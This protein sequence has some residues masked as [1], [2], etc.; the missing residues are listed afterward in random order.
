MKTSQFVSQILDI[1]EILL[2]SG[3]E[4]NRVEDTIRRIGNAYGYVKMDVFTITSSIVVTVRSE[5]GQ[6]TTQTR[7]I[8][9]YRTDMER[10]E[11]ANALSRELC[12]KTPP[13]ETIPERVAKLKEPHRYGETMT[14]VA[15]IVAAGA[16]AVFF[17]GD[18]WDC[19]AAL[20]PAFLMRRV[21]CINDRLRLN[22][23]ISTFICA[24]TG[25]IV[26]IILIRLGIGHSV[27]AI[28]I[29]CV[30]LMIP[31]LGLTS[32]LRDMI[33]GDTMSGLLGLCEAVIKAIVLAVGFTLILIPLGL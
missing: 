23:L 8:S 16:F 29:G 15:Y 20:L 13:I 2:V 28:M 33:T 14:T 6:I 24:L 21:M 10:V 27:D 32:S 26:I 19:I 5:D 1:G 3:A 7:R 17:G 18:L 30:M 11:R 25:S 31:G 12:E 9:G 22:P 4:V